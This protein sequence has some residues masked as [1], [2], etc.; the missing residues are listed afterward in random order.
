MSKK[1]PFSCPEEMDLVQHKLA[2]QIARISVDE[3]E[4]RMKAELGLLENEDRH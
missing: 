1:K 4:E 2:E 3:E